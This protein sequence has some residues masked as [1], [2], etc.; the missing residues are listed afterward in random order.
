MLGKGCIVSEAEQH[1]K[2][3]LYRLRTAPNASLASNST[4]TVGLAR[5]D[6]EPQNVVPL[7]M[8]GLEQLL[9]IQFFIT[10][11]FVLADLLSYL[12]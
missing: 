3:M 12:Q 1:K 10:W 8:C 9:S 6:L 4:L 11:V 5:T 7:G 2:S